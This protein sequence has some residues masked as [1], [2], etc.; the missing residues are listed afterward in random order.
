MKKMRGKT[1]SQI[2]RGTK[3][4]VKP[5]RILPTALWWR[6]SPVLTGCIRDHAR[7][8]VS[9]GLGSCDGYTHCMAHATVCRKIKNGLAPCER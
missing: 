3:M 5:M 6:V 7:A 2:T 4:L 9:A 8:P 1:R